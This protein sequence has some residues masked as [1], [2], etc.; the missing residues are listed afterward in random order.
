MNEAS[1]SE[2]KCVLHIGLEKTGTT[3]I[4]S[5]LDANRSL[6]SGYEY[7]AMSS[8]GIAFHRELVSCAMG[9]DTFDDLHRLYDVSTNQDKYEFDQKI[10]NKV[11][12]ELTGLS[13]NIQ[14]VIISSEHFT[15]RLVDKQEIKRLKK[16]LDSWFNEYQIVLYLRPQV[17][18][19]TSLY[20]TALKFGETRDFYEFMGAQA[21]KEQFYYYDYLNICENWAAV[22]GAESLLTRSYRRAMSYPSGVI[23]DFLDILGIEIPLTSDVE[24][25]NRSLSRFGQ[26]VLRILNILHESEMGIASEAMGDARKLIVRECIGQGRRL[27]REKKSEFQ[28]HF[29]EGNE[30]LSLRWLEGWSAEVEEVCSSEE[31]TDTM[32]IS[33]YDKKV[34]AEFFMTLFGYADI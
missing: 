13:D 11:H 12:D 10:L 3:T 32:Y 25:R 7:H 8:L 26:D 33:A 9:S 34:L 22:F 23:E 20:S 19:A 28:R 6:L 30:K 1:G 15:S 18:L 31:R 29:S 27:N 14:S 16:I 24:R 17:E 5:F 21:D 4:Q 2:M